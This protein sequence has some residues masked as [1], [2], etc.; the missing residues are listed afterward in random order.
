MHRD[1]MARRWCGFS[2]PQNQEVK[3]Q[4]GLLEA[5]NIEIEERLDHLSGEKKPEGR[6]LTESEELDVVMSAPSTLTDREV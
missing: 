1:F 5:T 6:E 3:E 4:W 2:P